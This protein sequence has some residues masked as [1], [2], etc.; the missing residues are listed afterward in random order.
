MKEFNLGFGTS[1]SFH[2]FS[3]AEKQKFDDIDQAYLPDILEKEFKIQAEIDEQIEKVLK[4][5]GMA[6]VYK[7]LYGAKSANANQIQDQ[8][9]RK[10]SHQSDGS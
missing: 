9:A 4:R 3:R 7:G 1:F 8:I 6:K 5:L 10:S 2:R